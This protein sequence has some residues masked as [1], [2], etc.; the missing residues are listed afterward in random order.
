MATREAPAPVRIRRAAL[1]LFAAQGFYATGIREI[2]EAADIPTSLL[3]HYRRSKEEILH[4]LVVEGLSRHLESSRQALELTRTPEEAL[5]AMV[6]VHVLVPVR[7]PEMARLME[8]EVRAL[9]PASQK[10]VF[11]MRQRSDT[12]W[13]EVLRAGVA[14]SVFTIPDMVLARRL[15]R[16]MCTGVALWFTPATEA[17]IENVVTGMTDYA[18]GLVR[19]MRDGEP[20]RATAVTHP[21]LSELQEIVEDV[22]HE[23]DFTGVTSRAMTIGPGGRSSS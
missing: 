18:L 1:R 4:D 13:E 2:A 16:R 21:P 22:H 15:L 5:R 12:R 23:P 7:N 19:A 3:Y 9:S 20:V 14:E 17:E 8:S 10:I 11:A 6:A